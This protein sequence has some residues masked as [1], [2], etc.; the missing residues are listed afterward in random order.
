MM[1][2]DLL[3]GSYKVDFN[4][5][6]NDVEIYVNGEKEYLSKLQDWYRYYQ[7]IKPHI[8]D[9]SKDDKVNFFGIEETFEKL[10]EVI[11]KGNQYLKENTI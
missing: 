8:V 5:F 6:I 11:A 3:W 7:I 4:I 10:Y 2:N 1:K 9:K